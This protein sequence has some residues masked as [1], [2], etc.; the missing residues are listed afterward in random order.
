MKLWGRVFAAAL[1]VAFLVSATGCDF[2]Q[3]LK[4][5]DKLRGGGAVLLGG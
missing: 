4:A 1:V 3:K 2:V 5:R